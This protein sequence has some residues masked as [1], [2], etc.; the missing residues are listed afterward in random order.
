MTHVEL[1]NSFRKLFGCLE[2]GAS[3]T[4]AAATGAT[5]T[6]AARPSNL[7]SVFMAKLLYCEIC[8]IGMTLRPSHDFVYSISF[9]RAHVVEIAGSVVLDPRRDRVKM[10][11][12]AGVLRLG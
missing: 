5:P 11:N 7:T 8:A 9:M 4:G 3:A 6:R 10:G 1:P 12:F 2:L